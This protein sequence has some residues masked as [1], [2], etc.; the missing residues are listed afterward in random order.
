MGRASSVGVV[1]LYVLDGPGIESRRRRDFP[2]LSRPTLGPTQPPV[3][4]VLGLLPGGKVRPGRGVDHPPPSNAKVRERVE[5]YIF[6][7]SWPSRRVLGLTLPVPLSRMF[8][9][10]FVISICLNGF[11]HVTLIDINIG[12][13]QYPESVESDFSRH[14]K[15]Q[16]P[17]AEGR[18]SRSLLCSLDFLHNLTL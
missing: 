4:W 5:L 17:K 15:F 3:H 12:I 10:R 7:P 8:R 2:H 6:S 11:G 16:M 14:N 13:V 18:G 1:T 9:T